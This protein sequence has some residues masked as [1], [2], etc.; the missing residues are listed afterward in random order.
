MIS[1]RKIKQ[2]DAATVKT[3]IDRVMSTEFPGGDSGPYALHDLDDPVRYY[4]GDNDIFLVAE[5]DREIIGTIAIKEDAPGSALL[6]RMFVRKDCRGK[7]YG[8]KLMNKAVE[9]CFAQGYRT[10][11]FRGTDRMTQ[12]LKLCLKNG[13]K[14][15]DVVVADDFKMFI[16]TRKIDSKC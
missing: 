8:D 2:D 1:I 11:S 16:L 6:R 3:L 9:F 14:E 13:F 15:D 12:A 7:G 5:K 10:V 4:G